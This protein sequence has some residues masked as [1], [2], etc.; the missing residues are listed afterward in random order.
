ML[1][2][3]VIPCHNCSDTIYRAVESVFNQTHTDWELI[4]VNNNSEDNTLEILNEIRKSNPDRN[5]KVLDEK[6]KG[7][8]A[9]RN[10]GLYEA[11]GEWIQF[12]DADDELQAIKIQQQLAGNNESE[13][14]YSPYIKIN[15]KNYSKEHTIKEDIWEALITSKAGITSANLFNRKEVID[16][17]GWDENLTSSQEYDL[18]FR[19]ICNNAKFAFYNKSLTNV[20]Y[21]EDSISNAKKPESILK[22]LKLFTLLRNKMIRHLKSEKKLTPFYQQQYE[23]IVSDN[24]VLSFRL[25]PLQVMLDYNKIKEIGFLRKIKTNLIFARLYIRIALNALPE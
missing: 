11:K 7:A 20:Y 9:A 14:I 13:V 4:L 12:L 8:P 6:K 22:R 1:V 10:K 18:M 19:L 15:N 5:I 21:A 24:Y 16:V 3:V 17:D 23:K 25:N 2:S